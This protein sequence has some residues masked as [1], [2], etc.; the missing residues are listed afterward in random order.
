[1][2]GARLTFSRA[3]WLSFGAAL[4]VPLACGGKSTS[5]DS[6]NAAG[7]SN[8]GTGGAGTGGRGGTGMGAASGTGT[9]GVTAGTGGTIPVDVCPSISLDDRRCRIDTDCR[10]SAKPACCGQAPI[11]GVNRVTACAEDPIACVGQCGPVE[12]LTD[13]GE[14]TLELGDVQVRCEIGEPGAGVCVSYIDAEPP[15]PPTYCDGI[16]CTPTE[17]CVHYA[18]PGGPQPPCQPLFDGGSCPPDSKEDLCPDT[19]VRGCIP[20]RAAPLSR[21]VTAGSSCQNP[22]DCDCLPADI[23]GGPATECAG[24]MLRD[25]FCVDLSP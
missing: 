20:L 23:C 4:A 1:V 24:V 15:P 17:V 8:G 5:L 3:A 21:C 6:E 25:V 14:L 16:L 18:T 22:V 7:E 2:V 12:W 13:T 11:H 10:L 9:G 19:G